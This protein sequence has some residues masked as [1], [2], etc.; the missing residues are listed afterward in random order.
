MVKKFIL[1]FYKY[2][3][4]F[5]S[6]LFFV[7]LKRSIIENKLTPKCEV[8]GSNPNH[9]IRPYNFDINQLN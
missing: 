8:M 3:I 6:L 2:F 7:I 9:D 4:W 1:Y 5:F